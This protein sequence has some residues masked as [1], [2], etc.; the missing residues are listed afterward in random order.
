MKSY[1]DVIERLGGP[2]VLRPVP[3]EVALLT[4]RQWSDFVP[5]WRGDERLTYLGFE[6]LSDEP[7]SAAFM[8][9]TRLDRVTVRAAIVPNTFSK[10]DRCQEQMRIVLAVGEHLA[11]IDE[12]VTHL[13]WFLPSGD[14]APTHLTALMERIGWR[15]STLIVGTP[16]HP[17]SLWSMSYRSVDRP[18][19][20]A[21]AMWNETV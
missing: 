10:Q 7:I 15:R 13:A 4:S 18:L 19:V 1:A 12:D 21:A 5:R 11:R 9:R 16:E 20:T 8:E 6:P 2:V 14:N 3:A 17:C